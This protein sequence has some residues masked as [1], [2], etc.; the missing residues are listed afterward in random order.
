MATEPDGAAADRRPGHPLRLSSTHCPTGALI[1]TAAGDVDQAS[2]ARLRE[3]ALRVVTERPARMVVSLDQV[4]FLDSR[5]SEALAAI[6]HR[7]G[8]LGVD[9]RVTAPVGSGPA[10]VLQLTGLDRVFEFYPSLGAALQIGPE[11]P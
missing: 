2:A 9:V 8:D 5:G 4:T 10:R 3:Y 7:A 1:L 6:A 11:P